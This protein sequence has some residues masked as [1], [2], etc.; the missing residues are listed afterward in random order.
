M[1]I[2]Y[3]TTH[4]SNNMTDIVTDAGSSAYILIYTGSAAN[5]AASASGTLL[6]SLPC[7]STIG[8]VS[9]GV[10]TFNAITSENT[11]NAGTAA[12]WR[13]C[14]SSAGTTCVAQGTVGTSGSDLNF[15]GGI[16]WTSGETIGI[17]SFTITACG[18]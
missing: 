2:Q 16:A 11:G 7:S 15:S 1:A 18:A 13:L 14:T 9:S 3:S 10:L 17:T 12:Q 6:V 5:C 4:R 8:T